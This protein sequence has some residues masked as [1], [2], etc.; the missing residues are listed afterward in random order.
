MNELPKREVA[1]WRNRFLVS[2]KIGDDPMNVLDWGKSAKPVRNPDQETDR[3]WAQD[4]T[5]NPYFLRPEFHLS[6]RTRPETRRRGKIAHELRKE[7]PG[8][9]TVRKMQIPS[10]NR[11]AERSRCAKSS[12]EGRS[13]LQLFVR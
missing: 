3:S 4:I 1:L 2:F 10:P 12:D 7:N 9:R 13:R 5:R 8:W 6:G 11:R